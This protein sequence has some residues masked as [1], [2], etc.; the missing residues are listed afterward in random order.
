[1]PARRGDLCL[2][3]PKTAEVELGVASARVAADGSRNG[4]R[5]V[6][7]LP[8][9]FR[10]EAGT[11]GGSPPPSWLAF[12]ASANSPDEICG[13]FLDEVDEKPAAMPAKK[14]GGS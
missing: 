4:E 13:R 2:R 1:M 9:R 11:R 5:E 10:G 3:V 12:R 8:G 7:R 6:L 14:K